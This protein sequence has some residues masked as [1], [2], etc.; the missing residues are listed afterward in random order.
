MKE[1]TSWRLTRGK[2]K[3]AKRFETRA[4]NSSQNIIAL[5]YLVL[6]EDV[7]YLHLHGDR[8]RVDSATAAFHEFNDY[9]QETH[10]G[11][12][13]RKIRSRCVRMWVRK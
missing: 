2:G 1:T 7:L 9:V 12:A 11:E 4:R 13:E 5:R 8:G 3:R 6:K 10:A